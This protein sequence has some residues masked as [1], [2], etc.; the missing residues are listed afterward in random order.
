MHNRQ[1]YMPWNVLSIHSILHTVFAAGFEA[2]FE[3]DGGA[4]NRM[5]PPLHPDEIDGADDSTILSK[6]F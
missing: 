2:P 5:T 6:S 4:G 1:Q 3:D